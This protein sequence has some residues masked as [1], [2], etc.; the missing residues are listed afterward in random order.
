VVVGLNT[1]ESVRRIKGDNRPIQDE[2]TR[3][4]ILVSLKFVD[5]VVTFD[6]DTPIKLIEALRP[7]IIV[8]GGDYDPLNVVGRQVAQVSIAPLMAN[9]SSSDIVRRIRD[10][11]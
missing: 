1:D 6:E 2:R 10:G 7:D 3:A 5:H 11:R 4:S 8:K 9:Q